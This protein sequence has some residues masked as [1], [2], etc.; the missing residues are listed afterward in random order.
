MAV[1]D[2][3]AANPVAAD[4]QIQEIMI[5]VAADMR[6]KGYEPRLDV[7]LRHAV[8]SDPRYSE[9]ARQA[10]QADEVARAKSGSVQISGGAN[11]TGA[12]GQS[13]DV[14]DILDELV[15]R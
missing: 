7:M 12:A 4:P 14:G 13:S 6:S 2:F 8:A 15:P 9:Q 3:V 5:D 1:Q 10:H 11:S